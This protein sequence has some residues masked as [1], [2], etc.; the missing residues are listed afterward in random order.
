MRTSMV[1][2]LRAKY[3]A[4]AYAFASGGD[5]G[6]VPGGVR[7]A[8]AEPR[9]QLEQGHRLFGVVELAGDRGPCPV[10]GDA[11]PGVGGWDAGLAAQRGDDRRVDV[12]VGDPPRPHREQQVDVLAGLAV[13]HLRL[14]RPDRLPC[15]DG[16]ADQ[17]VDGLGERGPGLVRGDVEQADGVPG[18]HLAGV[19]GDRCPVVLPADAADPEPGDLVAALSGEQPGQRGGADE[20]HRVAGAARDRGEVAGLDV[21]PG[22]QQL[23]PDVVGDDARV[24]ADMTHRSWPY[25]EP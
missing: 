25:A 4:S 10:A 8:V 23:G 16:L 1:R 2:T 17:G 13:Q 24:R 12:G 9:L 5:L 11:A 20:F 7:A 14:V 3:P 18:E 6:V 19:T 22:P 15:L 21:Q